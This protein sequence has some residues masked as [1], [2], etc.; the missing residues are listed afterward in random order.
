MQLSRNLIFEHFHHSLEWNLVTICSHS[1]SY[2]QTQSTGILLLTCMDLLFLDISC[3]W[4][5]T[6][7]GLLHLTPLTWCDVFEVNRCSMN[8]IAKEYSVVWIY[9]ILFIHPPAN[10]HLVCFCFLTLLPDMCMQFS[11]HSGGYL[12]VLTWFIWWI[13]ISK[14]QLQILQFH[15]PIV[16]EGSNFSISLPKLVVIGYKFLYWLYD[17]QMFFSGPCMS[18]HFF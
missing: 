18:F 4:D 1:S 5:H 13:S 16:H 9:Y 12:G 2:L 15:L 11:F 14:W 6:V 8:H 17:F 7:C 3:K 10:G